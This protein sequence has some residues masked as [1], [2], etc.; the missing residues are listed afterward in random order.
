MPGAGHPAGGPIPALNGGPMPAVTTSLP[1]AYGSH[2]E[3]GNPG[4]NNNMQAAAEA[5]RERE[6][7]EQE[8]L[9][10]AMAMS[11]SIADE[12]RRTSCG[13]SRA[14][15]RPPADPS[16]E[17]E[18]ADLRRALELSAREAATTPP[19]VPNLVDFSEPAAP[20]PAAPLPAVDPFASAAD[21]FAPPAAPTAPR[22]GGSALE[23][24]VGAPPARMGAAAPYQDNPFAPPAQPAQQQPSAAN[25]FTGTGGGFD[26][27]SMNYANQPPAY[28]QPGA[29]IGQPVL[30]SVTGWPAQ[31]QPVGGHPS[32]GGMPSAAMAPPQS[33]ATGA[34]APRVQP[35]MTA[36]ADPFSGLMQQPPG[37]SSVL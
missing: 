30:P 4:G 27:Y 35:G 2:A 5:A 21:P 14:A 28:V 26:G 15:A 25:A 24:L 10:L 33:Y 23:S 8:E 22:Y 37:G 6:R 20:Q 1:G 13:D 9:E 12:E 17:A 34:R 11:M 32:A 3:P 18:D 16:Q 19:A 29:V 7:Q 31:Q 36:A